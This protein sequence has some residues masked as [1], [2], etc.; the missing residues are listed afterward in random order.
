MSLRGPRRPA[1]GALLSARPV[2]KG[3][4]GTLSH[5]HQGATPRQE[6]PFSGW[7]VLLL[8]PPPGP[9]C[10][11]HEGGPLPALLLPPPRW[12][13][14]FLFSVLVHHPGSKIKRSD[15]S[16]SIASQSPIGWRFFFPFSDCPVGN[17]FAALTCLGWCRMLEPAL[18]LAKEGGAELLLANWLQLFPPIPPWGP[19]LPPPATSSGSADPPG[20]PE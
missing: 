6:A 5:E 18:C 16:S 1:Q 9:P 2:R 13:H 12:P 14:L 20:W 15:S 10:M 4:A 17:G 7:K 3:A 8:R 11:P 19:L